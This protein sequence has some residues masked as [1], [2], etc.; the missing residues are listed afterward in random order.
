MSPAAGLL[1]GARGVI[2]GVSSESSIGYHLAREF[3][4]Q[5]AE[6]AATYRPARRPS[7]APV[8]ERLGVRH[9]CPL[10]ANDEV[11]IETAFTSIGGAF[12][13]LDFVI[14]TLVHVPEGL[15]ARPLLSVSRGE[16]HPVL[17]ASAYSLIA[18]SRHALPWLERSAH[19]RLVTLTSSSAERMTPSYHAAGIAKAALGGA[20]LYLA[21]ELGPRGVLCNAVAFSLIDTEGAR[22]AVGA[23]NISGTRAYLEKRALTRRAVEPVHVSS[24]VA[25]FASPLCQNITAEVLTVDGGYARAYF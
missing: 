25:F 3:M 11:S 5:G 1:A 19:P 17:D 10:E 21:G 7:I 15:L 8:L 9:H 16:M 4:A 12:G 14:H 13:R 22:R 2:V 24:A 6:L 18:V 20:L 23:K